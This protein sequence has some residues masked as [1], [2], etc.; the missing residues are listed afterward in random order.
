MAKVKPIRE[1]EKHRK[2]VH[3]NKI[4]VDLKDL[5]HDFCLN[6]VTELKPKTILCLGGYTNFDVFFATQYLDYDIHIVNVDPIITGGYTESDSYIISKQEQI[7]KH[8]KF[9]GK[10]TWIKEL[11]DLNKVNERK[12][13]IIWDAG[14]FAE[15]IKLIPKNQTLFYYHYD[16]P[17]QL[18]NELKEI[19]KVTPIQ[20]MSRGISFHGNIQKHIAKVIGF[21]PYRSGINLQNAKLDRNDEIFWPYNKKRVIPFCMY[22]YSTETNHWKYQ[23]TWNNL[24]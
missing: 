5:V 8:F 23:Y 24:E 12:W 9:K 14:C 19:D 21:N 4:Y 22:N 18:Y 15:E 2:W 1:S 16:H 11:A 10:Y 20:G 17:H 6:L 7:K 13:D 3:K